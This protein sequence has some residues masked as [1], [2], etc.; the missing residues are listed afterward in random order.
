MGYN[1]SKYL[2][3]A[4]MKLVGVLEY[5]GSLYNPNGISPEALRDYMNGNADDHISGFTGAKFLENDGVL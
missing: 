4:G 1:V 2:V 5:E 3:E